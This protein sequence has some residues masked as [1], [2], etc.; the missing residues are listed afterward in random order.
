MRL[1]VA[2]AFEKL[3]PAD[4]LPPLL[5]QAA[6]E[7]DDRARGEMYRALGVLGVRPEKDARV[8]KLLLKAVSS[9]KD[10]A[11]AHAAV[12][13]APWAADAAVKTELRKIVVQGDSQNLRSS[14]IWALGYSEDKTLADEFAKLREGLT[15]RDWKVRMALESAQQKLSGGDPPGYDD[16]PVR[17]LP[18]PAEGDPPPDIPKDWKK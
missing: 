15:M 13:I 12:A 16:A 14:A 6:R 5:A 10:G 4:G 11:R 1:Q 8:E 9:S 7:K 2:H 18:H 17:F 3:E